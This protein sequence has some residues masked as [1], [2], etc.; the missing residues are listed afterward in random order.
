MHRE[1]YIRTA[2]ERFDLNGGKLNNQ[3]IHLT[4]NA[5]QRNGN[6][7]GQFEKGNQLSFSQFAVSTFS[8][9]LS[10]SFSF[11]PTHTPSLLLA[12]LGARRSRL[13]V[14]NVLY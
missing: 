13:N 12:P 5:I 10:F 6:S 1:G 2:S 9:D 7:Y 4:N 8:E 11:S 14:P 3:F